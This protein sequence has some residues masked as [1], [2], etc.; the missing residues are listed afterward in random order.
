MRPLISSIEAE[1]GRYKALGEGAIGQL[2]D[3]EVSAPGP[4][5]R[6]LDRRDGLASLREPRLA[7]HGLEREM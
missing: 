6:Q 5:R 2:G 1:Y 3:A 4:K 7:L